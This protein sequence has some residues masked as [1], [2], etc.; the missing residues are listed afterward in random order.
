MPL[1]EISNHSWASVLACFPFVNMV[2][3]SNTRHS[4]LV[5]RLLEIGILVFGGYMALNNRAI[6]QEEQIK[7]LRRDILVV[8]E[9]MAIQL[10][11]ITNE[12]SRDEA[13][14][15]ELNRII[16]EHRVRHQ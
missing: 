15:K 7:A 11:H 8:Q 1:A 5:A 16:T 9:A 13:D 12:M 4:A 2:V 6:R 10:S 3:K 14:L